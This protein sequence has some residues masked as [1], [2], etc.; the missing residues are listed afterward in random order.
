[1]KKVSILTNSS[2]GL[3]NFRR[4][5]VEMLI[6]EGYEVTIVSPK[7]EKIDYFI[8]LGCH[9]KEISIN[10]R[11]IN[12]ISD[13][14]LFLKYFFEILQT[15]PDVVL[16]YTIK[17]N[18]FGGLACRLLGVPFMPNITGLGSAVENDGWL[19]KVTLCLY[20][21]SVKKA[22]CIFFQNQ[23]NL[24]FFL[25]KKLV[26]DNYKL[27]PGS[28]VNLDHYHVME[29]PND[30][31]TH[32]LFIGRIMREKGIDHYLEAAE[33][34]KGKYPNTVFH[35]LGACEENYE[36]ILKEKVNKGIVEY[37]GKQND[38][39]PYH[40]ISH[41]TIHPSY[42]PEGMSNVLLE[43]AACGRPV[44]TTDRNGC[45]EVVD[46]GVSGFLV[47]PRDTQDLI[48]KIEKFI[49]LGFEDK[50]RMGLS[51]RSRVEQ[52]FDRKIVIES[53]MKEIKKIV[54]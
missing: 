19:S 33:V 40:Q 30:D 13:A 24:Q 34:I 39:R 1:M 46:D 7:G 37:H 5:L 43:S 15:R 14:L 32:F 44:I 27:I 26:R 35:I 17:P 16:T 53:Y 22:H 41:C 25:K 47:R 11:G 36:P 9:F 28:G 20:K 42:Y 23:D 3:F 50:R 29:Y 51:G 6:S 48:D 52:L 8:G 12:P 10:R 2:F 18:V 54:G 4:E 31:Q 45:R 49:H 38:V 21:L